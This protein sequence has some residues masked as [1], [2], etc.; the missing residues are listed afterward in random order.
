MPASA[1]AGGPSGRPLRPVVWKFGGSSV[2]DMDR[3][4]RVAQRLVDA[5][6]AGADVVA[7]LSA[8]SDTTDDLLEMANGLT[9]QPDARELDALL[10]TGESMSCALAAIAVHAQRGGA[11]GPH[12]R[13]GGGQAGPPP[14][15]PPAAGGPRA[16]A[17]A[18]A[19]RPPPAGHGGRRRVH[20]GAVRA[21]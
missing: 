1:A 15:H 20:V 19:R 16:G 4:R 12:R 10:A 9:T 14:P 6:R 13:P 5:R 11:G 18:P 7:V 8:M 21:V 17:P 2:G 3:L